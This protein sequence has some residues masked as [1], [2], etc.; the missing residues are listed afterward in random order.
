MSAR[1]KD[2]N[3]RSPGWLGHLQNKIAITPDAE[4]SG[5]ALRG[6]MCTGGSTVVV[7]L[8]GDIDDDDGGVAKEFTLTLTPNTPETRFAIAKVLSGGSATG[9]IGFR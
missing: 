6:I 1:K 5:G 8:N 4:I 2:D 9:L 3:G 7:I